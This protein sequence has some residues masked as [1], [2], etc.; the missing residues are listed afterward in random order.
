MITSFPS[1]PASRSLPS[2]ADG[3]LRPGPGVLKDQHGRVV[4][5]WPYGEPVPHG[6]SIS[7]RLT[8]L[9]SAAGVVSGGAALSTEE[10]FECLPR[11]LQR[12]RFQVETDLSRPGDAFERRQALRLAETLVRELLNIADIAEQGAHVPWDAGTSDPGVLARAARAAA[13]YVRGFSDSALRMGG[14]R[15]AP[16]GVGAAGDRAI[17]DSSSFGGAPI[18]DRDGPTTRTRRW[19]S[20]SMPGGARELRAGSRRPHCRGSA[21]GGL[22]PGCDRERYYDAELALVQARDDLAR[23]REVALNPMTPASEVAGHRA[24]VIE[25]Q[26]AAERL[27][28]GLERL[29]ERHRGGPR[30]R[31]AGGSRA[32]V[33]RAHGRA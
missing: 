1:G 16:N 24:R 25:L 3:Y 20:I 11:G 27:E 7:R 18:S 32:R 2:V 9:D 22:V 26:F 4:D 21:A 30:A 10:V 31:R 14:A 28:A 19:C 13:D 5:D 29:R 15:S 17:G 12:R 33:R 6:W 8:A 23:V